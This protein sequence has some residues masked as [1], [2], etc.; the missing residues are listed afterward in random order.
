MALKNETSMLG[1]CP[2]WRCSCRGAPHRLQLIEVNLR[3]LSCCTLSEHRS[4]TTLGALGIAW[5]G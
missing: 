5:A 1:G 3:P 4:S 2:W